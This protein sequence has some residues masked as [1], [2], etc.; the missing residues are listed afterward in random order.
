MLGTNDTKARFSANA[1]TIARVMER[2]LESV[3]HRS[4]WVNS[5]HN[6]LVIWP[7]PIE[8]GLLQSHVLH[9]MGAEAIEKSRALPSYYRAVCNNLSVHFAD[10]GEW[11]IRFNEVDFMHLTKESHSKMAEYLAKLIPT[12]V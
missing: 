10:A 12:I 6:I 5:K 7:P 3:I 11:D 9:E 1:H 8:E 2:L 4:C